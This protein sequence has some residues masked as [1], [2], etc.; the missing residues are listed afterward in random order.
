MARLWHDIINAPV[1]RTIVYDNVVTNIGLA[2]DKF[3]GIFTAP[4]R[5]IY[6][7]SFSISSSAGFTQGFL[8]K[9]GELI[10]GIYSGIVKNSTWGLASS[11]VSMHLNKGDRM[12]VNEEDSAIATI[13]SGNMTY[14]TGHL[15]QQKNRTD[16]DAHLAKTII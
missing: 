15:I 8:V 13:H 3:T 9:N 16:N 10:L 12:F 6:E 7:F 1:G 5:G 11:T 4:V 14:F 2:Y